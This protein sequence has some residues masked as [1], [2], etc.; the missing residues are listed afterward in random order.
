M[1]AK[2]KIEYDF[3]DGNKGTASAILPEGLLE[4]ILIA[5]QQKRF[6]VKNHWSRLLG[7]Y[8]GRMHYNPSFS[9]ALSYRRL[10]FK[11]NY[12]HRISN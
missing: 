5:A 6:V 8:K 4:N 2:V 3:G 7:N 11:P 10:R 9:K 12:Q 1:K